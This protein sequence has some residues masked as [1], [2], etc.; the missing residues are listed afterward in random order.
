MT[1]LWFSLVLITVGSLGVLPLWL[2]DKESA[3]QCRR[4]GFNPWV[5]KDPLEKEMATHSGILAWRI[6]WAEEPGSLQ[7]IESY[8]V[9]HD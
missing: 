6:P 8:R 1:S 7:S 5:R 4:H 9:R 2:R 3:C